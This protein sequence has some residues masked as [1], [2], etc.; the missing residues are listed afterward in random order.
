MTTQTNVIVPT[1]SASV[2]AALN[3]LV[4]SNS[5]QL[6]IV[7][8]NNPPPG[9]AGFIFDII[10]DDSV[11]LESESTN[12]NT[13]ANTPIQDHVTLMPEMVTVGGTVAEIVKTAVTT[14]AVEQ[15]Q[16]PLPEI[17]G[18][19]PELSPGAADDQAELMDNADA[20]QA[21]IDSNDSLWAYYNARLPQQPNQTKQ[22]LVFG[23]F[24]QLWKGRQLMSVETP[25]GI[26]TNM[27][28]QSMEGS[29]GDK[30]KWS[31]QFQIT[32]KKIHISESATVKPGT[33]AGRAFY[34]RQEVV[35]NGTIGQA[36]ATPQ[37]EANFYYLLNNPGPTT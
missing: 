3:T 13:S 16:N 6:A 9:I 23:Y 4:L 34:Q 36:T 22:S 12:Y 11:S 5:T 30:S 18:L 32:F 35:Q 14:P 10:D 1:D 31:S 33:V 7:R 25:W 27:V 15:S 24:Y 29:Q 20:D 19:E 26:F 8:P 17:P 2:F 37:Q 28:I 21:G